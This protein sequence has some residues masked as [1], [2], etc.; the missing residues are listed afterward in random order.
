MDKRMAAPKE[1]SSAKIPASNFV[2][3]GRLNP[4]SNIRAKG[5]SSA[6]S[7]HTPL[8][9]SSNKLKTKENRMARFKQMLNVV[10]ENISEKDIYSIRATKYA[11]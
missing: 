9:E 4:N 1:T 11:K 3:S 6:K 8:N 10:N 7:Q 2:S 5:L